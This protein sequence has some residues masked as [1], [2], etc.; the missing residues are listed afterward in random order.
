MVPIALAVGVFLGLEQGDQPV[1]GL[2]DPV[3]HHRLNLA[4][5][6]VGEVERD[7]GV[8]D[9]AFAEPALLQG[10][11]LLEHRRAFRTQGDG[12]RNA[13][14]QEQEGQRRLAF[15]RIEVVVRE[16]V[17]HLLAEV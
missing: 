10:H 16:G 9:V 2:Q 5:G 3:P 7:R 17:T 13:I 8:D 15:E 14:A 4:V 12:D 11:A 6:L 1:G